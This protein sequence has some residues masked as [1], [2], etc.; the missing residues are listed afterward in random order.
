MD[1]YKAKALCEAAHKMTGNDEFTQLGKLI[2][3][4]EKIYDLCRQ[5]LGPF[6]TENETAYY[7]DKPRDLPTL[8]K[9]KIEHTRDLISKVSTLFEPEPKG[10]IPT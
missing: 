9:K 2:W 5:V 8:V 7:Y 10:N 1:F 3:K 6:P 4:L